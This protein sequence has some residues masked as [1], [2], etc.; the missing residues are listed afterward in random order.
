M[1]DDAPAPNAPAACAPANALPGRSAG[2]RA[3]AVCVWL[4]MAA[5]ASAIEFPG[6]PRLSPM[7][8][9]N[10][11]AG[12]HAVSGADARFELFVLDRV[13]AARSFGRFNGRLAGVV[14]AGGKAH[15]LTRDGALIAIGDDAAGVDEMAYGDDRWNFMDLAWFGGGPAAL[16]HDGE[17]LRLAVPDGEGSWRDEGPPAARDEKAARAVLVPRGDVLHLLWSARAADLSRGAIRH[18]IRENGAWREDASL[19]VGTVHAFSV[20]ASQGGLELVAAVGDPLAADAV[21]AIVA[22]RWSDGKWTAAPAVPDELARRLAGAISFASAESAA[23]RTW[24]AAGPDGVFALFRA[25][26]GGVDANRLAPGPEI[27]W[28][29]TYGVGLAL[30]LLFV[31]LAFGSCRRSRLLCRLFPG[32]PPDLTGR[33]V[34][35]AIDW[36]IVSVGVAVYHAAAGDWRIYSELLTIESMNAMFWIN[37]GA[38]AFYAAVTEGV[39]GRTPGKYLMGLRVRSAL[40]GP[41]TAA[42]ALLRNAMRAADMFP[43]LFPGLIGAIAAAL[44]PMRQ[45]LGD[46]MSATVVRRH[47]PLRDRRILLASAS[48]RRFELLRALG[49]DVQARPADIDEDGVEGPTPRETAR[50]LAEEKARAAAEHVDGPDQLVIAAD[51]M[52]VVD[53]Q[54]LGKP[55]DAD[56]AKRMLGL[57]SGRS[58]TVVTG[59]MVWDPATGRG[60]S[61]AEETEVEFRQLT[62][63]EIDAYVATGDPLDKAGAYGVQTGFLVKQVR[64]SLSNVAGLPMERLQAIFDALDS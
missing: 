4:A 15:A 19:P 8:G 21:P 42:Q 57:L 10:V 34:A 51:T 6:A 60:Y 39:Y 17:W 28:L 20:H 9:G 53:G 59:V 61:D 46:L 12:Y 1:R 62:R 64:G 48:P 50:L 29:W 30:P 33:A 43:L 13:S 45:R 63:R 54:V 2:V 55:K 47:L 31:L 26:G 18:M 24:L 49:L 37:L 27:D 41:P 16:N 40:G 11:L 22:R 36:C 5:F 35:L 58:H 25:A 52:V 14:H 32:R 44:N 3:V 23:G 7:P 38:L 56:D